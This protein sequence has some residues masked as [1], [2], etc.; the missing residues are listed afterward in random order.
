IDDVVPAAD[1]CF[2]VDACSYGRRI[3]CD[4]EAKVAKSVVAEHGRWSDSGC[5]RAIADVDRVRHAALAKGRVNREKAVHAPAE[6]DQAPLVKVRAG[7][8]RITYG[9]AYSQRNGK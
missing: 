5:C 8:R 6:F 3:E 7:S 4:L 1:R 2:R 9:G